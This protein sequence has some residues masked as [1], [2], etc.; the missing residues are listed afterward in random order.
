MSVAILLAGIAAI[1]LAVHV[2]STA[3]AALRLRGGPREFTAPGDAPPV[4][5]V[6]PLAGLDRFSEEALRAILTLDYP[7]YEVVFCVAKPLD[8]IVPLARAMM[9]AHPQR[10]TSL[11]FGE[12]SING[13]PKLN[14]MAKGWRA[15]RHDWIAVVDANL[16]PPKDY[17][18]RLLAA[19]DGKTGAVSAP[20]V[21]ARPETFAADVECAFLNGYQARWQWAADSFGFGFAQGKTLF[22]R[23]DILE[24]GGGMAALG[25][26]LAEDAATT[27]VVRR[28]GKKVRL[29]RGAF[30]QPLGR[31]AWRAVWA[32]QVRWARLRRASFAPFYAL[33][34]GTS[35]PLPLAAATFAASGLSLSPLPVAIVFAGLWWGAEGALAAAAGWPLG[36]RQC[37]A[38]LLRDAVMPW[39]WLQAWFGHD[40]EWNGHAMSVAQPGPPD[41]KP[42]AV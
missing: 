13:N 34:I 31:R 25:G 3:V 32:R 28:M 30:A 4:S 29:A 15:A 40:F 35:L 24:A 26:E 16:L 10:P 33:E 21:G 37:A 41:E 6:Q 18:Q 38:S 27:K 20:P 12:D 23:R 5:V 42:A 2:A 22:Y 36:P 11:L 19:W 17:L 14:N 1:C 8:P 7:D 39:L 9:A